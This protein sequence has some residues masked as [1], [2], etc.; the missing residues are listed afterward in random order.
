MWSGIFK[1]AGL[2]LAGAMASRAM[3]FGA[4]LVIIHS[5]SVEDYGCFAL[6]LSVFNWALIFSHLDLYAGVSRMVGSLPGTSRDHLRHTI[7][8][9]ARW[10]AVGAALAGGCMAALIAGGQTEFSPG[11]LIF[12]SGLIPFSQ[13]SINDGLLKGMDRFG[14][15]AAVNLT[16]GALKLVF[17]GTGVWLLSPGRLE[18]ILSLFS[19]AAWGGWW[20]SHATVKRLPGEDN[21][22][23]KGF[24]MATARSLFHFSK[25][26]CWTDLM[27]TGILLGCNLILARYDLEDL[28]RFNIVLL[29]F[30]IL[31]MGFGA[32][33][34]VL[35]PQV[36]GISAR[37][38]Q[39]SL[40]G[41]GC[42]CLLSLAALV[43]MGLLLFWP[44]CGRFLSL[45]LGNPAYAQVTP[46]LALILIAFPFRSLSAVNKGVLQGMGRADLTA[47]VAT[48]TLVVHLILFFLFYTRFQLAG[49]LGA[50]VVAYGVECILTRRAALSVARDRRSS[51]LNAC[52]TTHE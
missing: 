34:T 17:I 26:V 30:S 32:M 27:N 44:P 46:L 12:M 3:A 47:R 43:P 29:V 20:I 11:L 39:L 14:A 23:G 24:D 35:I 25:W 45:V 37:G 16:P 48:I 50:L 19:L 36:S 31:Q 51:P 15:S 8:A 2:V 40:P 10:M 6:V 28:A 7:V 22:P 33:T 41:A 5:F 4:N 9:S 21:K 38:K 18:L 1:R 49:G 42:F 13:I 52:D